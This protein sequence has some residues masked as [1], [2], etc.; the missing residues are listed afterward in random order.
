MGE[1]KR[2]PR[3]LRTLK[4][5]YPHAACT[6]VRSSRFSPPLIYIEPT[7]VHKGASDQRL[8]YLLV[9]IKVILHSQLSRGRFSIIYSIYPS[10]VLYNRDV[11]EGR[12]SI[13]YSIYPSGIV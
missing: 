6:E 3:T 4:P 1:Q 13:V 12:C 10:E 8:N 11:F 7:R 2:P 5:L 9:F